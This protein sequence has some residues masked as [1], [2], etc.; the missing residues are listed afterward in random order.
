MQHDFLDV[1]VAQPDTRPEVS[2]ALQKLCAFAAV[3]ILE[4]HPAKESMAPTLALKRKG[5]DTY[6]LETDP[7]EYTSI[8]EVLAAAKERL[9][10]DEDIEAYALFIDS[11][12]QLS[13]FPLERPFDQAGNS[14]P[15]A[16]PTACLFLGE[17]GNPCGVRVVQ[18]YKARFIRGGATPLGAPLVTSGPS[19]LLG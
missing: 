19:L 13:G 4:M 7:C 14:Y 3:S 9:S 2:E 10:A 11:A 17:R 5:R 6:D 1:D 8:E 16:Q 15:E 18:P 12:D